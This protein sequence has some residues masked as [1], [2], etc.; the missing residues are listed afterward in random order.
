MIKSRIRVKPDFLSTASA[1]FFMYSNEEAEAS[2]MPK[3]R[4]IILAFLFSAA[5]I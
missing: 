1:N 3:G 4:V 2:P 5:S